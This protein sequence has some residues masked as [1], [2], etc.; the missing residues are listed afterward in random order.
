M[1]RRSV[2]LFVVMMGHS[3]AADAQ[4][5][6]ELRT[7][8][9]SVFYQAGYERDAEFARAWM[10]RAEGLMRSKYGVSADRYF[11]SLYLHPAPASGAGVGSATLNCCSEQS[12]GRR[13][14]SIQYLT[15]SAQAWKDT[16]S[17]TSL[18]LPFDDNYHAKVLMS[19]YIPIGHLALQSSRSTSSAWTYY[20][21]TTPSWFVQGLQEFDAIFHTTDANRTLTPAKLLDWARRNRTKFVCCSTLAD[22]DTIGISDA[23]NGGA[24]FVAFLAAQYGEDIHARLLRNAAATFDEALVQEIRPDSLTQMFDRFRDWVSTGAVVAQR[25]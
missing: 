22:R 17:T 18:G 20:G 21:S 5:W 25:R 12:G 13:T 15:P 2:L 19:E 11:I 23:Y 10:D 3:M 8:N 16:L 24:F 14:G 1:I 4:Q 9:Y 7:T 6:L